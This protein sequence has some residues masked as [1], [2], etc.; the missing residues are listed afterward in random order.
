MTPTA[1]RTLWAAAQSAETNATS[2]L[3]ASRDLTISAGR[4]ATLQ[5]AKVEAERD[6]AILTQRDVYLL[7]AQD[8]S[9]YTEMHQR[10]SLASA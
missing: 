5:A 4:D 1:A 8:V 7:S 9:N 2:T 6:V 3:A 10:S